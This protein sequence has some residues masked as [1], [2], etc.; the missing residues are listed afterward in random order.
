[1]VVITL[2]LLYSALKV[3]KWF[4]IESFD[5]TSYT[6]KQGHKMGEDAQNQNITFKH[7]K[8]NEAIFI[9]SDSKTF[10]EYLSAKAYFVNE[11]INISQEIKVIECKD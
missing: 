5:N 10:A 2:A 3:K 1:M 9:S 6:I 7:M 11:S 8:L 4:F